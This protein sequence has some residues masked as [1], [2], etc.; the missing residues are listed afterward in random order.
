MVRVDV[1]FC[2]IRHLLPQ[3]LVLS[4]RNYTR[5]ELTECLPVAS[6]SLR[7]LFN[8]SRTWRNGAHWG[9][10]VDGRGPNNPDARFPLQDFER[11]K[12]TRTRCGRVKP[13]A[14]YG[15]IVTGD[16][17]VLLAHNHNLWGE[18]HYRVCLTVPDHV[19]SLAFLINEHCHPGSSDT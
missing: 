9:L 1:V 19:E 18:V 6:M 5:R 8:V 12:Q 10:V 13:P 16:N 15:R 4:V 2:A 17:W 3:W 11:R 14:L 7:H